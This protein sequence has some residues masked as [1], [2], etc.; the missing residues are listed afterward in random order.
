MAETSV[1]RANRGSASLASA[2]QFLLEHL[3]RQLADRLRHFFIT[4]KVPQ[5][6]DEEVLDEAQRNVQGGAWVERQIADD[7][8][9]LNESPLHGDGAKHSFQHILLRREFLHLGITDLRRFE[10][11]LLSCLSWRAECDL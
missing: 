5:I 8:V 1:G 4:G 10:H 9:V 2:F 3:K 11:A 7:C 6:G